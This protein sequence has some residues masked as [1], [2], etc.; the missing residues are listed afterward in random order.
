MHTDNNTNKIAVLLDAI[1]QSPDE[2]PQQKR[3][4]DQLLRE[5]DKLI[6]KPKNNF[7]SKVIDEAM[8]LTRMAI[9]GCDYSKNINANLI[10]K[11][12]SYHKEPEILE[13]RYLST[14]QKIL[15]LKIF[16]VIRQ[17]HSDILSLDAKINP[18]SEETFIDFIPD[19]RLSGLDLLL[20][21]EF[22]DNVIKLVNYIINEGTELKQCYV[23]KKHHINAQ[24]LII[25]RLL[26]AQPWQTIAQK[27]N[28][29][30][31]TITGRFFYPKCL[32]LLK[33]MAHRFEV[34]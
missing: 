7:Y 20:E 27:L 4:F 11:L 12:C 19:Y 29:S 8:N 6:I 33:E 10:R 23:R 25:E 34:I 3:G 26:N 22:T 14:F 2:S 31:G 32:P 16:Y 21:E 18:K 24:I 17:K 9:C 30:K 15:K 1:A 28:V 13:R 5:T